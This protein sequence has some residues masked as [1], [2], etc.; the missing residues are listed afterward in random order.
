MSIR[1]LI[2]EDEPPARAKLKR[3]LARHAQ[4]QL[5]AEA[6]GG[7]EALAAIQQLRPDL[8]FLDIQMPELNGFEILDALP[9][10]R[11]FVV[12]FSTAHDEHALRAFDAH[13]LDYLLKP[14]DAERFD[15]ALAKATRQLA[16]RGSDRAR[17]LVVK[18][19][20]GWLVIDPSRVHRISADGKDVL[21]FG[22]DGA[23]RVRQSL[24]TLAAK[25]DPAQF[26]RV[27]RGEIVRLD[28]VVRYEPGARGDGVLTLC[29]GSAVSLSR[30]QRR[31]F[32]ERFAGER[33]GSGI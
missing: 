7:R 11:E 8:V 26:V 25:L 28:A 32:S 3:L 18:T 14:Y 19:C 1:V 13:A 33:R 24:G 9:G 10:A 12:I 15:A 4:F 16:V 5:V 29:D 27:H 20:S 30:T 22:A 21:I 17:R 31:A 23:Q 6:D 2:A